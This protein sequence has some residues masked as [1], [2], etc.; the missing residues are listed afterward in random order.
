[1][2]RNSQ[3]YPPKLELTGAEHASAIS[4]PISGS[5]KVAP[6]GSIN[7]QWQ[8]Y[9]RV[10]PID[11]SACSPEWALRPILKDSFETL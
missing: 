2:G 4:R 10:V 3:V 11:R 9:S 1:M 6:L 5:L 8:A 7:H